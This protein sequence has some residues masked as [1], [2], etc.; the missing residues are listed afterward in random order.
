MIEWCCII[1]K[2]IKVKRFLYQN[3]IVFPRD[4]N[5]IKQNKIW[6][7]ATALMKL[8]IPKMIPAKTVWIQGSHRSWFLLRI[9]V[10]CFKES[11]HH[12]VLVIQ[13][14][15]SYCNIGRD[16]DSWHTLFECVAW[17]YNGKKC[18]GLWIRSEKESSNRE[19]WIW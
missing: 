5:K 18:S 16:D 4:L 17:K 15:H 8:V 11:R 1:I 19:A 10:S 12:P 13:V 7:L 14:S 6:T 2:N 9:L 3:I